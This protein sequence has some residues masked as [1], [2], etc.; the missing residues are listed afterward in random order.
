MEFDPIET[1]PYDAVHR[2]RRSRMQFH[3]I[4]CSKNFPT[5]KMMQCPFDARHRINQVEFEVS[6]TCAISYLFYSC[7]AIVFALNFF[8]LL[9][10]SQESLPSER[11]SAELRTPRPYTTFGTQNSPYQCRSCWRS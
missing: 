7:T 9:P 6:F 5:S 1:C 10:V 4:T 2:I 3:I 8:F 11:I